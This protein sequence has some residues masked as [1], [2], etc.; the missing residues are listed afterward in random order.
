MVRAYEIQGVLALDNSFNQV[1]LDHVLLVK[2]ASCGVVTKLFGGTQEQVVAALSQAWLDGQSLRTYR[3]APNT[4]SRKSWAAGDA[5]S[6]AVRLSMLTLQGE[7]GYPSALTAKQWGFQDVLFKN[8]PITFARELGSYVMENILFK[9][10]YPAEFH[11]QTAVACALDLHHKCQAKLSQIEKIQITTHQ[12]AMRIINKT[13]PL[14]NPADRDH[15]LQYMVAIALLDGKLTADS[16][17]DKRASDHKID[18]LRNKMVVTE[19]PQYSKD[20]LDPDKRSIA[21]ALE[22]TFTDGT[23]IS[24]EC[25]YPLGHKR[26]RD[27]GIPLMWEKFERNLASRF[28]KHKVD[29]LLQLMKDEKLLTMPVAEFMS[30]WVA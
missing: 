21:N 5:T 18:D 16:Y 1:G 8:K 28:D 3:H 22:I 14:Y 6:R 29:Q 4:G 30:H 23:K 11:A 24:Q 19:N 15:C 13:G 7:Q 2:V 25:E 9:I 27:E 10:A 12:A 17:E 20:Y 26:R